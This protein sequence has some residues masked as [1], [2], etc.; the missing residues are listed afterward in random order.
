MGIITSAKKLVNLAVEQLVRYQSGK[1]KPIITSLKHFNDSALGGIFKQMIIVIAG[2]SG[3]GKTYYLQ[4]IEEDMFNKE[5]NPDCDDYVLLR[6]NYEM[7]VFRLILRKL[8]RGLN[9]TMKEI[10][11]N[12][13][14]GK[15]FDKFK[16]VCDSERHDNIFYYEEPTIPSIWEKD[17]REFLTLHKAKKH[18]LITIDHIALTKDEGNKKKAIDDIVETCNKFKKEFPN[19]SFVIISQ[20]NREI[21]GRRDVRD[22]AP[23]RGDLYGSDTMY[24]IADIVLIIHNPFKLGHQ[25]YM[26][27][28]TDQYSYLDE[29]LI[30]P[31]KP[32]TNFDT[33]NAVFFHYIKQRDIEDMGN[34][35]DIF[36][37]RLYIEEENSIEEK[38]DFDADN[39]ELF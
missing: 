28:S 17:I 12:E 1:D 32:R 39:E 26:V 22:L 15:E 14:L 11:F 38:D 23:N 9:K 16:E 37:E 24:H 3:S 36:V 13:P 10:L 5:L 18:V 21:E 25:K 2:I 7:S 35:K 31:A 6:C 20:L 4:K 29:F 30:D 8:K 33:K 27:V 19:V 34:I